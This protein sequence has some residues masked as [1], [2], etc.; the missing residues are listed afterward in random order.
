[1]KKMLEL[2]HTVL[3]HDKTVCKLNEFDDEQ[4]NTKKNHKRRRNGKQLRY[5]ET[6]TH[7]IPIQLLSYDKLDECTI[8]TTNVQEF[9]FMR[10]LYDDCMISHA[11]FAVYFK[12]FTGYTL[13]PREPVDHTSDKKPQLQ[14]GV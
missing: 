11:D 8:R 12:S 9:N 10:K 13:Q 4:K 14:K 2:V 5:S 1:M 3:T 7:S 6:T